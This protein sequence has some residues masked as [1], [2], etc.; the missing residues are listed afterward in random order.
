MIG[1][2]PAQIAALVMISGHKNVGDGQARQQ[3]AQHLILRRRA[4]IHEIA[5]DNDE[6]RPR[7]EIVEMPH[8]IAQM[9]DC[10]DTIKEPLA[11][12]RDVKIADLREK[13]DTLLFLAGPGCGG[14]VRG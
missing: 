7:L 13:H 8:C 4:R 14:Y 10:I 9:A 6:I 11:S 12:G 3:I 1:E 5:R 2:G